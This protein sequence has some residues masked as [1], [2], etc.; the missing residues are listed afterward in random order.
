MPGPS[1]ESLAPILFENNHFPVLAVFKDG[2][3]D[4][5]PLN[6]GL[7]EGQLTF[8]VQHEHVGQLNGLPDLRTRKPVEDQ[9]IV[10]LDSQLASLSFYGRFHEWKRTKTM[11]DQG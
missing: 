1:L 5:R 9:D 3:L 2:R 11:G 8:I 10:G 4:H 6:P 7:A